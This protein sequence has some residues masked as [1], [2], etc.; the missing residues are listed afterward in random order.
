MKMKMLKQDD[1]VRYMAGNRK[2]RGTVADVLPFHPQREI[3]I[4]K[5]TKI[6]WMDRKDVRKLP[7][8]P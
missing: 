7:D 1:R 4:Q 5:R 3:P 6:V 8:K 2:M